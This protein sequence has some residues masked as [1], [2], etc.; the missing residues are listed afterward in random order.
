VAHKQRLTIIDTPRVSS[1]ILDVAKIADVILFAL[2][3]EEGTD[4][5]GDHLISMIKAQ[6]LPAVIG[7]LQVYLLHFLSVAPFK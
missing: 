5:Y 2:S 4:D 7:C 3:A 6:G 1:A